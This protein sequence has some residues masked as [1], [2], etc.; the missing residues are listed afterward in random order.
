MYTNYQTVCLIFLEPEDSVLK[1]SLEQLDNQGW[2]FDKQS[3]S[4]NRCLSPE[5]LVPLLKLKSQQSDTSYFKFL[6]DYMARLIKTEPILEL[7]EVD[8]KTPTGEMQLMPVTGSDNELIIVE[9]I[10]QAIISN[11]AQVGFPVSFYCVSAVNVVYEFICQL[12]YVDFLMN[13]CWV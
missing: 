5:D 6:N 12:N 3:L 7:V 8:V 9:L 2:N 1:K 4:Q 10:N 11:S 13:V